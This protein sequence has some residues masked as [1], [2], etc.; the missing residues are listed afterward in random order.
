MYINQNVDIKQDVDIKSIT[1]KSVEI[2]NKTKL[3][4]PTK[5][6]CAPKRI[7]FFKAKRSLITI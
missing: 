7:S 3:L 5:H 6:V 4:S 2:C 1:A